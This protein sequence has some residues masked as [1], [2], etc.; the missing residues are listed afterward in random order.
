VTQYFND[1]ADDRQKQWCVHCGNRIGGRATSREHVPT[2]GLLLEPLPDQYP[3]LTV[4]QSCNEGH[5][6]DEEYLIAFLSS[7]LSGSTEPKQQKIPGAARILSRNSALRDRIDSSRNMDER[8]LIWIPEMDRVKRVVVK[9]ARCHILY[10]AAEP[11]WEEP[12]EV[13]IFAIPSAAD[14]ELED[15]LFSDPFQA[16]TEV[17]SRWMQ[18]VLEEEGAFDEFGF[19]KFQDGTYRFR[20]DTDEGIS[21][22]IIM[23]NYLAAKVVWR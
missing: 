23:W 16:W 17:G 5:S 10:E 18:R 12:E 4:C 15:F 14:H 1:Y 13:S 9:N 7:V 3:I 22:K 20:I 2:K 11:H 6:L 19:Y 8:G 21:A